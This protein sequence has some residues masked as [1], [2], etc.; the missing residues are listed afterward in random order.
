MVDLEGGDNGAIL[1][2]RRNVENTLHLGTGKTMSLVFLTWKNWFYRKHKVY[3]NFH[4]FKIPYI[5]VDSVDKMEA[6][7]EGFFAA[8]ELRI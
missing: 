7:K 1:L 4:L 2:C 6:M 3:S 8:D 5:M